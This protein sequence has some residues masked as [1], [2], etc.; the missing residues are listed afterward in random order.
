MIRFGI[1]GCGV[2]HGTHAQAIGMIEGAEVAGFYDVIPQRA[3]DAATKYGGAAAPSLEALIERSDAI[4]VCVPS[5]LH[6]EVA[7]EAARAGR[8]VLVEKPLDVRIEPAE[9]L[10]EASRLAR[11]KLGCISQHRFAPDV[12]RVREAVHS[13]VLGQM[14]QG[15][16]YVKW[17]RSQAYYDSAEWRG[18]FALDGGGCLMNQ[19]VHYVDVVQWIM[20]PIRAVRAQT[21][22]AAHRIEVEDIANVL[23]EYESGAVGVI[24]A[25]TAFTP[26]FAERIEVHGEAGSI[27]LEGDHVRSWHAHGESL[28]P[29]GLSGGVGAAADPSAVWV[30][31]HR[32]QIEDFVH[33]IRDD[34]TPAVTGEDALVPLRTILAIYRSAAEDGARVL[35]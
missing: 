28:D 1:V 31:Q 32:L 27:T 17:Y 25:S 22:T 15:D 11:V 35:V 5:G 26:G 29:V 16:M 6:S 23:I 18:T 30:E 4:S 24:Q 13:G 14:L 7:Q 12:R 8:H 19:G 21:R 2:I 9:A 10:I 33:A 20:G 34:R 3:R